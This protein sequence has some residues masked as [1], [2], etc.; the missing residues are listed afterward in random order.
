MAHKLAVL[1]YRLLTWG[2]AYVDKGLQY[3]EECHRQQQIRLLKKR[4]ATLG[5]LIVEPQIS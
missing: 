4:A 2:H 3:Y 5:F 1:V